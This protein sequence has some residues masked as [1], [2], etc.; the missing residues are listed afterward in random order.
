MIQ[1]LLSTNVEMFLVVIV[2]HVDDKVSGK[3]RRL[4]LGDFGRGTF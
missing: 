2:G 3:S 1:R 4:T